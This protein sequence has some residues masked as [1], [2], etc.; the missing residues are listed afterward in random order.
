MAPVSKEFHIRNQATALASSP[1]ANAGVFEGL[2]THRTFKFA[3]NDLVCLKLDRAEQT[4]QAARPASG[5]HPMGPCRHILASAL[6]EAFEEI[7]TDPSSTL[8]MHQVYQQ[9]SF[10]KTLAKGASRLAEHSK[11]E[12]FGFLQPLVAYCTY[13]RAKDHHRLLKIRPCQSTLRGE[14]WKKNDLQDLSSK[15]LLECLLLPYAE[16]QCDGPPLTLSFT[17]SKPEDDGSVLG[18]LKA[19]F[20][21]ITAT[22]ALGD[23]GSKKSP[24]ALRQ[25]IE[26]ARCAGTPTRGSEQLL[27]QMQE[28]LRPGADSTTHEDSFPLPVSK[29]MKQ[30]GTYVT[31]H[32]PGGTRRLP[33]PLK[34]VDCPDGHG[35]CYVLPAGDAIR[36]CDICNEIRP[37]ELFFACAGHQHKS[38]GS[39]SCN[40]AERRY[41]VCRPCAAQ[42]CEQELAVR[43]A[44]TRN[45]LDLPGLREALSEVEYL[46]CTGAVSGRSADSAVVAEARRKL[47][48]L[49]CFVPMETKQQETPKQRH[50]RN[51]ERRRRQSSQVAVDAEAR[52]KTLTLKEWLEELDPGL[53]SDLV[54][55]AL[56]ILEYEN[57][58]LASLAAFLES[59]GVD[60]LLLL[61]ENTRVRGA[62][63]DPEPLTGQQELLLRHGAG[64]LLRNGVTSE[65]GRLRQ[66]RELR[67]ADQQKA[68]KAREAEM[69]AAAAVPLPRPAPIAPWL[70]GVTKETRCETLAQFE[71]W[72]V[73][74][75]DDLYELACAGP[76]AVLKYLASVTNPQPRVREKQLLTVAIGRLGKYGP[77]A[78]LERFYGSMFWTD[79]TRNMSCGG[80]RR[81]AEAQ[82]HA[83][84]SAQTRYALRHEFATQIDMSTQARTGHGA[85]TQTENQAASVHTQS[86]PLEDFLTSGTTP[87]IRNFGTQKDAEQRAKRSSGTQCSGTKAKSKKK[88]KSQN[89]G[90]KPKKDKC[91]K[92][93]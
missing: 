84:S 62:R 3:E 73:N 80:G 45:A 50:D 61:L 92:K 60:K 58:D 13:T 36:S 82:T 88:D 31:A 68:S 71:G 39:Q 59:D 16:Y 7:A 81:N 77:E 12:G 5:V 76:K 41:K 65:S 4:Y 69:E 64:L 6:L 26:R 23:A 87:K 20:A 11:N 21:K 51:D 75:Y 25:A 70:Q 44:G 79:G 89:K 49:S 37:S 72:L 55:R 42:V 47:N 30:W 46:N 14:P 40:Y 22:R 19:D 48:G 28:K 93:I 15:E 54:Q 38:S 17:P 34:M 91:Q 56:P 27:T 18:G 43:S 52:P 63:V 85:Q 53:S 90:Q 8:K 57:E 2:Q 74:Q 66:A 1:G 29:E 32:L 24:N 35:L 78:E 10:A 9:F 67:Q 33:E 83:M 86:E